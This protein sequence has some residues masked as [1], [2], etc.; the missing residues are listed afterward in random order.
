MAKAIAI[1]ND[2]GFTEQEALDLET[3][4]DRRGIEQV[5]QQ[6]SEICGAKAEHIASASSLS[7]Q[8]GPL[9]GGCGYLVIGRSSSSV[10]SSGPTRSLAW[11]YLKFKQPDETA[12]VSLCSESIQPDGIRNAPDL[13]GF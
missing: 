10:S 4:I 11:E 13:P 2:Y 8:T 12:W 1:L 9:L 6:I 5:L 7:G 3:L